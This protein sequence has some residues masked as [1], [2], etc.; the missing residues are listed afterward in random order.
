MTPASIK[1]PT[2]Q[3]DKWG[4]PLDIWDEIYD[5]YFLPM[6]GYGEIYDPSPN[7]D[8]PLKN[9]LIELEDGLSTSWPLVFF[10]N[11][12][13][14]KIDPWIKNARASKR[15]GVMLL[16]ARTDQAW[17]HL[18]APHCRVVHIK[19]RIN[20]INPVTGT[21]Q[22]IDAK[23]GL[24]KNGAISCPSMLMIFGTGAGVEYWEPECH[25]NKKRK[26]KN[27]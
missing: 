17:F 20:Y 26:V 18:A 15:Y 16:P 6:V 3:G 23:T 7:L 12:P 21:T 27:V 11:P 24:L 9:T 8:R 2:G 22:V 1:S 13:W 10:T 4:T 25:K 14:S 5:K 19:G